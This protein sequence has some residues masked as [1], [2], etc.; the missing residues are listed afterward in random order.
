MKPY[1]AM[2][3][4]PMTQFGMVE[5]RVT[6]GPKKEATIARMAVARMV[7]TEAFPE[8]ATQPTDSP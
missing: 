7:T 6:K 8:M 2:Q 4:P 3:T 1:S 5:R